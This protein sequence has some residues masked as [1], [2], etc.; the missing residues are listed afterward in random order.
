[1]RM[2]L[3]H[4]VPATKPKVEK[5]TSVF[6]D[7]ETFLTRDCGLKTGPHG[8][9]RD[10]VY[11][12]WLDF[13][14]GSPCKR[15][16]E[17]LLRPLPPGKYIKMCLEPRG[18][19]KSIGAKAVSY[20]TIL[21]NPSST[22]VYNG[23]SKDMAARSV[24]WVRGKIRANQPELY[25]KSDWSG[26]Q[27]T[28]IRPEGIGD[29]PTMLSGSPDAD[30]AGAH[31]DWQWLDDVVCEATNGTYNARSGVIEWWEALQDQ[32]TPVTIAMYIGTTYK[33]HNLAKEIEDHYS[34]FVEIL[35]IGCYDED[36]GRNWYPW[37][38]DEFL[39]RQEQKNP[40]RF[41][42]Q[43][44]NKRDAD[45]ET[46][47]IT[48]L[49]LKAGDPPLID[50]PKVDGGKRLD[51]RLRVY[52]L[53]DPAQT[54][55]NTKN[56]SETA[57]LIIAK[58]YDEMRYIVDIDIGRYNPGKIEDQYLKMYGK[59]LLHGLLYGTLEDRGPSRDLYYL[60]PKF[61]KASKDYDFVPRIV[62]VKRGSREDKDG[63]ISQLYAPFSQGKFR[64]STR[65]L[66]PKMF[67]IDS[68]GRPAGVAVNRLL[69]CTEEGAIKDFPDALSDE[70]VLIGEGKKRG[71]ACPDPK[72]PRV[73]KKRLTDAEWARKRAMGKLRRVIYI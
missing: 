12:A 45:E 64:W 4:L 67:R 3:S 46:G 36:T 49:M 73:K 56:T 33:G 31:P 1:M 52:M 29:D 7:L 57:M 8:L 15:R 22:H 27:F 62:Q 24:N 55:K 9:G 5:V 6:D 66:P 41:R 40:Q 14:E 61:A 21:D 68:K 10:G 39:A 65:F 43:Y 19:G 59:W 58:D 37:M 54:D 18:A 35:K 20:G 11:K 16:W 50:D 38:S 44:L 13:S 48:P 34:E 72:R 71:P 28:V 51:P 53:C 69:S 70:Q 60:I 30:V 32:F 2:K 25:N 47:S 23:Q 17:F 63:R 26:N 42:R